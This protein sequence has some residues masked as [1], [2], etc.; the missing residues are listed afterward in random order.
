[1]QDGDSL[2]EAIDIIT[3]KA[4]AYLAEAKEIITEISTKIDLNESSLQKFNEARKPVDGIID[5][6]AARTF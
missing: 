5:Y 3:K 4:L 6:L 1:M 2:N